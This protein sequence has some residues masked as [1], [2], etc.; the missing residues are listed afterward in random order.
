MIRVFH[1]VA[2]FKIGALLLCT[3]SS[4]SKDIF[5]LTDNVGYRFKRQMTERNEDLRKNSIQATKTGRN[6]KKFVQC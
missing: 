4:V 5:W 2:R 6:F 3:L 1:R